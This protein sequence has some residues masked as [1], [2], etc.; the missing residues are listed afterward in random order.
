[1]A[2]IALIGDSVF[3]NSSYILDE[4][5]VEKILRIKLKE[6]DVIDL[7]A[8][9]GSFTDQVLKQIDEINSET[10]HVFVSTG[11]NDALWLRPYVQKFNKKGSQDLVIP[12][13]SIIV[14]NFE[15]YLN[16]IAEQLKDLDISVT[17]CTIYNRIPG[18]TDH[19]KSALRVFNDIIIDTAVHFQFSVL[20]L[21]TVCVEAE[22]FAYVSPIEPSEIGGLKIAASI[23]DIIYSRS[24]LKASQIYSL[25]D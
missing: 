17:F 25:E 13:Y 23:S 24:I 1:M 7:I 5:S 20:D 3:D 8:I 6:E 9:D 15:F 21:R 19:E 18:L 2:R 4:Q 10:T 22:D 12:S 16:L 14:G 11:G